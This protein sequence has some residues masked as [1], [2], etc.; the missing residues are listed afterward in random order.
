MGQARRWK[1]FDVKQRL[2]KVDVRA[3]MDWWSAMKL[4]SPT[5][6][7]GGCAKYSNMDNSNL[8]GKDGDIAA[9]G[10]EAPR[11]LKSRISDARE[12]RCGG[13]EVRP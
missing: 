11:L 9:D 1:L 5:W 7:A 12:A 2:D 8:L 4:A 10:K 3:S 6:L 13:S